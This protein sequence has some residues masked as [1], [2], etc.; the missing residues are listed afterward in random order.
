MEHNVRSYVSSVKAFDNFAAISDGALLTAPKIATAYNVPDSAGAG[1]KIGIISLG[2]GFSQADLNKSMSD[3]GLTAPTVT[4]VPVDGTTNDYTADPNSADGENALDLVCVAGMVPQANIVLYKGQNPGLY[5]GASPAIAA[6]LNRFSSFGNTI[7]RAVDENCDIITIS[8]GGPERYP[9]GAAIRYF[10]DYMAAALANA[11]AKSISVFVAS[12]DYGSTSD[13]GVNITNVDYP[14]SSANVIAVGGTY[15]TLDGSNQ[16]LAETVYNN[17]E[18]G[19]PTGF[20]GSGGVSSHI[21]LPAWQ[22]NLTYRRW[23]DSNSSA[24]PV[25][26]LTTRGV[27][28]ISAAM[29]AYGVS[30]N[31][32]VHGFSGTS[33]AAPIAAGIFARYIAIHGRR[34]P[35]NGIHSMLY[36]NLDAYYD[37]LSG[38]NASLLNTGYAASSDWDPVTGLGI[39]FGGNVQQ[40]VASGGTVIK[41]ADNSWK[42]VANVR[43]KTGTTTWSNVRA[44]WT[45]TISGWRQTY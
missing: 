4:F 36:A 18:S 9:V 21:P 37:I 11:A 5:W 35:V 27:P 17:S 16:R 34:P 26:S 33:A 45:K 1:V 24:G 10:G 13:P 39:P 22:A 12:G 20:G 31:N 19:Y 32:T 8:W 14:S 38:D 25:T 23:F 29:N 7:Q 30:I 28:D 44:I 3:L 2:G 15:L 43:V 41:T 6:N 42:S 40:L